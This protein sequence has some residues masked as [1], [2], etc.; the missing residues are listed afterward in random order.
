[1][2]TYGKATVGVISPSLG[3]SCVGRTPCPINR[4]YL[5]WDRLALSIGEATL[6]IYASCFSNIPE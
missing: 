5:K 4:G 6:R 3:G 2:K 1:M